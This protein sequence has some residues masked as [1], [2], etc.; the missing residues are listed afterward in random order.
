MIGGEVAIQK[1]VVMGY[2]KVL[3]QNLPAETEE[4]HFFLF[5]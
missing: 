2:L 1:N 5:G 3:C 4:R